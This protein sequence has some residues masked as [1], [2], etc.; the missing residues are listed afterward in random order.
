MRKQAMNPTEVFAKNLIRLRELQGLSQTELAK[1]SDVSR[2]TVAKY[3]SGESDPSISMLTKFSEA[4]KT[5]ITYF[6]NDENSKFDD[7]NYG[8]KI[9]DFSSALRK[10]KYREQ[11]KL[12]ESTS[13]AVKEM[14]FE[15]LTRLLTVEQI[16][17]EEVRFKNPVKNLLN[18]NTRE[19]AEEA[20]L[21]LRK[22][23]ALYDNPFANVI[24][25]LER[26]GIKII[27][28][29][30]DSTFEGLSAEYMDMPI[31]VL[32]DAIQEVTR[33]RFTTLHELGHLVLQI[34]DD[35][36]YE[37]IERICDA[38][39]AML[40]LPKEL[41]IME[42]GKSRVNLSIRELN[43][44][45]EKYGISIKA[46]LVSAGFANI[47]SWKKYKEMCEQ[48]DCNVE[49]ISSYQIPEVAI[50]FE[51]LLYRGVMTGKI[52]KETF[53]ELGGEEHIYNELEK[54]L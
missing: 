53:T 31:I 54:E 29:S 17:G 44:I 19:K 15:K 42:L 51:Q 38:F 11:D 3:E 43:L 30:T 34:P 13:K 22:K 23:W 8:F 24:S 10:V 40:I 18:I 28:V 6:F 52:D 4:L 41:L 45:K 48:L 50:R 25:V 14:A 20:A 35:L 37:K 5:P 2:Q 32:N 39:A 26:E 36:N 46:L 27:E 16:V 33:K 21:E 47:I 9:L 7:F 12:D 49:T 1:K